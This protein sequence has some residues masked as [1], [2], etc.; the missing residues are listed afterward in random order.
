MFVC[1]Q[2]SKLCAQFHLLR[3]VLALLGVYPR[4]T[5]ALKR[6]GKEERKRHRKETKQLKLIDKGK[7]KREQVRAPSIRDTSCMSNYPPSSSAVS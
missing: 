5:K 2:L 6:L 3:Y 7:R 1:P 4:S